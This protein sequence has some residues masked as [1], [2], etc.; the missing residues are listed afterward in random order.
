MLIR[1]VVLSVWLT[2]P[3]AFVL[4][5][6]LYLGRRVCPDIRLLDEVSEPIVIVAATVLAFAVAGLIVAISNT[7]GG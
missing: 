1:V 4:L 3:F 6:G 7:I 2:G 5:V